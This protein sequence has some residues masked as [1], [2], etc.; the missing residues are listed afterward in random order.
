MFTI[1]VLS[2]FFI[3]ELQRKSKEKKL[4]WK[5]NHFGRDSFKYEKFINRQWETITIRGT[6]LTTKKNHHVVYIPSDEEWR[7][8]PQ[9][10]INERLDIESRIVEYCRG[11]NYEI[12]RHDNS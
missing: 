8:L 3:S 11:D 7:E 4:G 5:F 10:A 9:W 2:I 6:E 1:V 12:F